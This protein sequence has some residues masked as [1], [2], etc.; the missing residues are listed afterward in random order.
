MTLSELKEV[1]VREMWR[2]GRGN[3]PIRL[4]DEYGERYEI[5]EVIYDDENLCFFITSELIEEE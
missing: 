3:L 4:L 5:K 2:Q 1:L